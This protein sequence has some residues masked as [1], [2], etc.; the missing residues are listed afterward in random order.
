[1][2]NCRR[3]ATCIAA[4]P[5]AR[6]LDRLV[7]ETQDLHGGLDAELHSLIG[8]V[9]RVDYLRYLERTFGFVGPL[10]RALLSTEGLSRYFDLRR[11]R[12]HDFIRRDLDALGVPFTSITATRCRT[13]PKFEDVHQALGW[14]YV[15]ERSTLGHPTVFRHLATIMPGDIAFASAYLKCYAGVVGEMWR[16]FV[17]ALELAGER[18]ED[19]DRLIGAA[20]ECL[21]C[22]RD[23]IETL[24]QPRTA[25]Q[26]EKPR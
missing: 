3:P 14:T 12:K 1:M 7:D 4:R 26:A 24:D 6:L 19:A 10:E 2:E 5:V 21:T 17:D 15:V 18:S 25:G 16:D 11:L 23:W 22:H 9:T 8:H 13:I 20:K